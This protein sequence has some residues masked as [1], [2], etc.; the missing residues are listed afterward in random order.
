LWRLCLRRYTALEA[1]TFTNDWRS[2]HQLND[3]LDQSIPVRSKQ[4][5]HTAVG[6]GS[7][8]DS[9][10]KRDTREYEL[11]KCYSDAVRLAGSFPYVC[12]MPVLK[13]KDD[14]FHFHMIYA[15][16]SPKGV[17]EFKKAERDVEPLMHAVRAE[18]Q[19]RRSFEETGQYSFLQPIDTYQ[20]S[21]HTR[22]RAANVQLAKEAV[23]KKLTEHGPRVSFDDIWAEWMQFA[24][25]QDDDL[26]DWIKKQARREHLAIENLPP[27]ARKL[28]RERSI[29]IR[30]V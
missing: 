19:H 3:I 21:R 18:A 6:Q 27:R 23:Q 8:S 15:T 22:Y 24:C 5:L 30:S 1:D 16:R 28:T 10:A 25:V 14:Q 2:D 20:E 29:V 4:R 7:G 13:S 12:T 9:F 26:Q 17:E 11:V